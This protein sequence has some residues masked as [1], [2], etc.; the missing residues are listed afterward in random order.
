MRLTR[1]VS[2]A[3]VSLSLFS[4]ASFAQSRRPQEFQAPREMS[5]EEV[6]LAKER[7]RAGSDI[8]R[9]GKDTT[10]EVQGPPWMAIGLVVLVLAVAAPFAMKAY[11]STA[12]EIR[13][14]N[15]GAGGR[16]AG[17][18]PPPARRPPSRPPPTA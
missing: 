10:G 3:L 12:Q 8:N 16:T 9:W 6:R 4:A 14:R 11:L 18:G 2:F 17:E 1:I 7:S 15:P 5:E 13:E